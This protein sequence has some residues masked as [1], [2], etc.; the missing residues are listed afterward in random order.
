METKLPS[1]VR[2]ALKNLYVGEEDPIQKTIYDAILSNIDEADKK[3]VPLCQDT[4]I[5]MFFIR[6]GIQ[7]PIITV[8]KKKIVEATRKATREIPLRPNAVDPITNRNSGDNTGRYI[9]WI[10]WDDIIDSESIEIGLYVAGGGS[11]FPGRAQVFSPLAGWSELIK[12]VIN[13][14]AKYGINSCPPLVIG[15]GIGATAEIAAILSKKALF[16]RIGKRHEN[17]KMALIEEILLKRLNELQFGAQGLKGKHGIIDV[18]IEYSYRH[19]ATF[20]VGVT[21]SCWALRR[22]VLVIKD[23]SNYEFR[24]Y[25]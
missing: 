9:P 7:S 10:Y 6:A 19:P 12:F 2:N 25:W 8:L 21:I 20:A 18:H 13:T 15:I 1:D 14:V 23:S 11:S 4:G 24:D 22:G 3:R 5:L 17:E 16:R